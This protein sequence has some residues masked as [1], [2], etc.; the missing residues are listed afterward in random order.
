MGKGPVKGAEASIKREGY[1]RI[2]VEVLALARRLKFVSQICELTERGLTAEIAEWQ[3]KA[4]ALT[5]FYQ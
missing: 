1:P 2:K 4:N 3:R 5:Q